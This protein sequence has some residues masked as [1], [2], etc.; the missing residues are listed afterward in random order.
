LK[1][2]VFPEF[3]SSVALIDIDVYD[4]NN[5]A[6]LK[7][8]GLQYIPT[9][10]FYDQHGQDETFVGVMEPQTLRARLMSLA[11]AQ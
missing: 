5:Q 7:S 3:S 1:A 10:I 4:P 2:Q 11:V 9:L 8:V 6:L